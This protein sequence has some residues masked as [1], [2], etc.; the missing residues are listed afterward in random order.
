MEG[1]TRQRGSVVCPSRSNLLSPPPSPP[2][3]QEVVRMNSPMRQPPPIQDI[4]IPTI[5]FRRENPHWTE[6][7]RRSPLTPLPI[8]QFQRHAGSDGSAVSTDLDDDV[9]S[10]KTS[11]DDED[12]SC[13]TNSE[14]K[15]IIDAALATSIPLASIFST[16]KENIADVRRAARETGLHTGLMR[17]PGARTDGKIKFL[18]GHRD[19]ESS[20]WVVIGRSA[21]AVENLVNLQ[22]KGMP[23]HFHPDYNSPQVTP[24]QSSAVGFAHFIMAGVLGGLVVLLGASRVL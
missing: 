17:R 10:I 19:S 15:A 24:A 18:F 21:E 14:D 3:Y 7:S 9:L 2:T 5:P 4:D 12:S 13:S 16:P 6:P 22:Q 20:W 1:H 23:G 11:N 8:Q